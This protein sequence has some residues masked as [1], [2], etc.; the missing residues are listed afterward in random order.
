MAEKT[1]ARFIQLVGTSTESRDN[2]EQEA[3]QGE[4]ASG[5]ESVGVGQL[6]I[7][8]EETKGLRTT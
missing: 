3:G 5:N 2:E 7:G 1:G 4:A 8:G 6:G